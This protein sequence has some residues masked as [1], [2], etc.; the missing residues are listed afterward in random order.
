MV[1]LDHDTSVTI[2]GIPSTVRRV[3]RSGY[4]GEGS[5][6]VSGKNYE[7]LEAFAERI[8]EVTVFGQLYSTRVY[9]EYGYS[10]ELKTFITRRQKVYSN[11]DQ[12]PIPN[13][14]EV[15]KLVKLTL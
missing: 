9:T 5:V 2:Q 7:T 14:G 1:A 11:H 4:M 6:A 13:G 10:P 15:L 12:S 3:L 8:V